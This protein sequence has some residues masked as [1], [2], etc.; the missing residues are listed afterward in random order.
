MQLSYFEEG[1]NKYWNPVT[2]TFTGDPG[3]PLYSTA[4][5]DLVTGNWSV[6]APNIPIWDTALTPG[7]TYDIFAQAIDGAGNGTVLPGSQGFNTSYIQIALEAPAPVTTITS[8]N[9]V[10]LPVNFQPS[11]V[12]ISGTLANGTTVQVQII[13]CGP[14]LICGAGNDDL[15]W[16]GSSFV[17]TNTFDGFVGVTGLTGNIWHMVLP[18]AKWNGNRK[19]ILTSQGLHTGNGLQRISGPNR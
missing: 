4:A 6:T 16:N 9:P 12:L 13:D 8:P 11:T 17:S 14:D 7:I 2:R 3:T 1:I 5:V 18:T 19:Y 10:G 15:D